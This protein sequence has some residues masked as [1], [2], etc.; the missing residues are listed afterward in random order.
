MSVD[1]FQKLYFQAEENLFFKNKTKTNWILV[2][3]RMR[4]ERCVVF[5]LMW[6]LLSEGSLEL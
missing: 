3:L 6:L 1:N 2:E 5:Q 4:I